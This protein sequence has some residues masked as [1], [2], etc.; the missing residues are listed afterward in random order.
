MAIDVLKLKPED[1]AKLAQQAKKGKPAKPAVDKARKD[2]LALDKD[3]K[4]LAE[5]ANANPNV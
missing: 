1:L 5:V 3:G 4:A 2:L